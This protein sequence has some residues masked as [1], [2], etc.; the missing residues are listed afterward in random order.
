MGYAA[1]V[2]GVLSRGGVSGAGP[3]T[4]SRMSSLPLRKNGEARL[5][6]NNPHGE[7]IRKGAGVHRSRS[8]RRSPVVWRGPQLRPILSRLA[9]CEAPRPSA[10]SVK[11][12]S[13]RFRRLHCC[14]C[15]IS[16]LSREQ[17][18][19]FP[20]IAW[21]LFDTHFAQFANDELVIKVRRF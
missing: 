1:G 19:I 6:L 7:A 11:F 16:T 15:N 10:G 18:A 14:N 8:G 4:T 20:Q 3:R 2:G 13:E 12:F 21:L 5:V 9:I 17:L